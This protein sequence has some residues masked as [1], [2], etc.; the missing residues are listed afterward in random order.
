MFRRSLGGNASFNTI[1]GGVGSIITTKEQLA[2][3]LGISSSDILKFEIKTSDIYA[4][5]RTTYTIVGT[6]QNE[7]NLTSY[8]DKGGKLI[9]LGTQAFVGTSLTNYYA[10]NTNLQG[11]GTFLNLTTLTNS[12]FENTFKI[13]VSTLPNN[14]GSNFRNTRFKKI[15]APNLTL[16]NTRGSLFKECSTL[17]LISMK[18]LTTFGNAPANTSDTF[19]G[20]AMNCLIEVNI[21]LASIN[22]GSADASLI[23]A[24]VNRNAIVNFYDNNGNFIS[25][26]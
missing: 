3:R 4:F 5:I 26:L 20:L 16:I 13:D 17:E 1:I 11:N 2:T 6:F 8:I 10:V 9:G 22:S 19:T 15:I 18:K 7:I 25:T 23:W 24:K 21:A 12:G 14:T